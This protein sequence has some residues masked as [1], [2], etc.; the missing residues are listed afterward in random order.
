MVIEPKQVGIILTYS[1][2]FYQQKWRSD[3]PKNQQIGWWTKTRPEPI[4][5]V[6]ILVIVSQD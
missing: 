3:Q 4:S 2:M 1:K 5:S 6:A